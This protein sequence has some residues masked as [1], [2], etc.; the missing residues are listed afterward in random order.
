MEA[1]GQITGGVAHDFNNLLTV[2]MGNAEILREDLRNHPEMQETVG[3]ILGAGQQGAE[4]THSLLAF[5]RRQPLEP[6]ALDINEIIADMDSML[7]PALG[8]D[9]DIELTRTDGLWPALADPGQLKNAL[10]NLA[11]NGRDA[12]G[13]GGQLMIESANVVLSEN[14]TAHY[15]EVEPG[16]YV[17]VAVSDNGHGMTQEQLEQAFEP[18]YSTKGGAGTGLG[19]SMV[20][21]FVKQL[22][23]HL[24]VYS[25]VGHGTTVK[26]Y[27]PRADA[28]PIIEG[29]VPEDTVSGGSETILVV[30]DDEMLRRYAVKQLARLGYNVIEASDGQDALAQLEQNSNVDL[31]FTDVIM[32]GGMTGR[33]VAEEFARRAPHIRV[34]YTSGYA[35]DSIMHHGRVN[36]SVH[37]LTKPYGG[38]DLAASVRKVL[39]SSD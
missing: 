27:L 12:M 4:L 2:I 7:R 9:I 26:M 22:R 33:D 14:Y 30:E 19:L 21:G 1:I 11:I 17:L 37:L 10:L 39:E 36:R 31:L 6:K 8:E 24:N 34:L 18:F 29:P 15:A 20:Y 35:E 28:P 32:P 3:A 23:G 25:E 16:E 5:A 38:Q 13:S